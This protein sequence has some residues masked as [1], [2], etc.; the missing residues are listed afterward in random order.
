MSW[1]RPC[2]EGR[3]AVGDK[4]QMKILVF[5]LPKALQCFKH[6]GEQLPYEK[7][8]RQLIKKLEGGNPDTKSLFQG[9][10]KP[11]CCVKPPRNMAE[12]EIVEQ[13]DA[14]KNT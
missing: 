2:I 4:D 14:C 6:A 5:I 12:K 7:L 10:T 1:F 9:L 11:V 3:I 13:I 8:V